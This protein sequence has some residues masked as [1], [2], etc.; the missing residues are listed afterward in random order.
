MIN[1]SF[2]F[3]GFMYDFSM[4]DFQKKLFIVFYE[5]NGEFL[6]VYYADGNIEHYENTEANKERLNLR[7]KKQVEDA[8][9]FYEEIDKMCKDYKFMSMRD[10]FFFYLTFFTSLGISSESLSASALIFIFSLV[11]A[12]KKLDSKEKYQSLYELRYDYLKHE[13][14]LEFEDAFKAMDYSDLR[15]YDGVSDDTLMFIMQSDSDK[16][17]DINTIDTLSFEDLIRMVDNYNAI[18]LDAKNKSLKIEFKNKED[19]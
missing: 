13:Y 6:T 4:N 11:I 12:L 19:K 1:S 2:L 14:F 15:L 5:E 9:D 17:L 18:V 16:P 7:M 3:G 10:S 8:K